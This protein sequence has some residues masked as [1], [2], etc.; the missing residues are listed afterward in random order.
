MVAV[1]LI[2]EL[3]MAIRSSVSRNNLAN[4][5]KVRDWPASST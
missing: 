2:A 1:A 3:S 4:A 5:N